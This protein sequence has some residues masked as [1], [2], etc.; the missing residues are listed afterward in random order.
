M[1]AH[2]KYADCKPKTP[3]PFLKGGALLK[4]TLTTNWSTKLSYRF[5]W[6]YFYI[7]GSDTFFRET[8][9]DYCFVRP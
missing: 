8:P 3:L 1:P 6:F 2:Y 4:V 7:V 5:N 9:I